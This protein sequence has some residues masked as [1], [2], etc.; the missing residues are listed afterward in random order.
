MK[1]YIRV[2]T[3]EVTTEVNWVCV[4]LLKVGWWIVTIALLP[5]QQIWTSTVSWSCLL[6]PCMRSRFLL[7]STIMISS[8]YTE[9]LMSLGFDFF[10]FF[11]SN[12]SRPANCTAE[13]LF[14]SCLLGINDPRVFFFA[15]SEGVVLLAEINTNSSPPISPSSTVLSVQLSVNWEQYSCLIKVPAIPGW[16]T[17]QP[18]PTEGFLEVGTR[19]YGHQCMHGRLKNGSLRHQALTAGTW[20]CYLIWRQGLCRC[21]GV[22]DLEMKTLSWITWMALNVVPC[23]LIRGLNNLKEN[24]V[25]QSGR[26][27]W[28]EDQYL[29]GKIMASA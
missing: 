5:C 21:D 10:L 1:K 28:P 19:I 11:S 3:V 13:G 16:V 22:V 20:K 7:C 26:E 15:G 18:S 27:D 25:N 9:E 12:T 17:G 4:A 14:T 6:A 8:V 29:Q 2:T 23:I 24:I